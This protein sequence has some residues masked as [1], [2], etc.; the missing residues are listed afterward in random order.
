LG[1]VTIKSE[2]LLR[3]VPNGTIGTSSFTYTITD[4][5]GFTDTAT[6]TLSIPSS[7]IDAVNDAFTTVDNSSVVNYN[8]FGNDNVG[9]DNVTITAIDTTGFTLGTVVI[10]SGGQTVKFTPNKSTGTSSFTYTITDNSNT[11]DT[12]TV[13]I[14]V[15]ASNIDA[16]NYNVASVGAPPSSAIL[17]EP[18]DALNIVLGYEPTFLTSINTTGFTLGTVVINNDNRSLTF[19]PNGTG[20]QQSFTYTITDSSG[21]SDTANINVDINI[22]PSSINAVN[23]SFTTN[24]NVNSFL[25]DPTSN[26]D[27]GYTPTEITSINS[28]GFTLGTL[29]IHSGKLLINVVPNGTIGT[30][31]F[32]YTITDISGAS[33]TATFTLTIEEPVN[34]YNYTVTNFSPNPRT[35]TYTTCAGVVSQMTLPGN[36]SQVSLGCV[37]ENSVSGNNLIISQSDETCS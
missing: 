3:F 16:T 8:L 27:L 31:T 28:T 21:A 6:I 4:V 26:D 9:Y 37:R 36:A 32:S 10:N 35:V 30:S 5:F 14:T 29:S 7:T 17:I 25:I 18:L 20:G 19:T 22:S 2:T 34:C 13:T 1:T 24:S 23:D 12:A 33:D 15:P 11:S